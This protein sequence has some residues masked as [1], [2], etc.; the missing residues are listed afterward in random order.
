VALTAYNRF[1][2]LSPM[3]IVDFRPCAA[4]ID[5]LT[6]DGERV[7]VRGWAAF[8]TEFGVANDAYL[9]IGDRHLTRIPFGQ[10]RPDIARAQNDDRFTNSGL[11]G[12]I[13]LPGLP[14]GSYSLRI[15]VRRGP[16]FGISPDFGPIDVR[17]H[18][19]SFASLA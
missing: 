5:E 6:I 1:I 7:S 4:M 15:V 16:V 11:A 9:L 12:T 13:D 17:G 18:D 8:D 2:E 14:S 3:Q 19:S 10:A